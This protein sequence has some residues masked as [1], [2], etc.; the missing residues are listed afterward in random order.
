MFRTEKDVCVEGQKWGRC[1][2][3]RTEGDDV[4]VGQRKMCRRTG[5]GSCLFRRTEE[6]KMFVQK[7]RGGKMFVQDCRKGKGF[8]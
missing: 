6:G 7:D 2:C 3:R 8:V 1:L 4:C 5:E